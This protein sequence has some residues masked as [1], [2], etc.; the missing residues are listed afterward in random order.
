MYV[1]DYDEEAY[2]HLEEWIKEKKIDDKEKT[3]LARECFLE[4]YIRGRSRKVE[5]N[6]SFWN[7]K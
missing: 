6:W 2:S 3:K 1:D 7:Q 4:G 5:E